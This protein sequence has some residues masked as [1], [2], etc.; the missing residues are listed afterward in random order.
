MF[1]G[2]IVAA[3]GGVVCASL[4]GSK[5]RN[6]LGWF[7]IGFLLPLIG[8]ILVLVLPAIDELGNPAQAARYGSNLPPRPLTQPEP[9]RSAKDEAL[10]AIAKLAKLRDQGAI[11]PEEYEAKKSELLSRV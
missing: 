2:F 9:A 7:V 1:I 3:I 5:G 10:D 4:A 11:S 8:I 6:A